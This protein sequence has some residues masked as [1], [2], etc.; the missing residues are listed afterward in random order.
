MAPPFFVVLGGRLYALERA[1]TYTVVV[2][3]GKRACVASRDEGAFGGHMWFL[4]WIAVCA[5]AVALIA[6]LLHRAANA[7][8]QSNAD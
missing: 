8:A 3:Y 6:S 5:C 2:W 1:G 4:G 7:L